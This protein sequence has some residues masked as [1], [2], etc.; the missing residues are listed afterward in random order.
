MQVYIVPNLKKQRTVQVAQ[1]AAEILQKNGVTVLLEEALAPL[2]PVP[3]AAYATRAQ[4]HA[5]ADAILTIGGDGTILHEAALALAHQKP[6]LGVNLGRCGFLATCEETEL[7]EKL[8]LLARGQYTL[9]T[10]ALLY[11]RLPGEEAFAAHALND[12]VVTKGRSQQAVEFSI[13]CDGI[14][15]E[16]YRGDGVI[17]ATPTGSTA[18]SLAAGGP[19]LDARTKAIVV[20]PICPHSIRSPAI[21]FAPERKIAIRIGPLSEEEGADVFVSSDGAEGYPLHSDSIVEIELSDQT[22]QLITFGK[23]DQFHAIDQKI[24]N[25]S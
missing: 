18:Y 15:V 20:T 16:H 8:G 1:L 23:A 14:S 17:V 19:I 11:A 3:G 13:F 24:K 10:R 12:I 6:I 22:V 9:D 25:R 7:E 5:S 2:C 4:C 21:V